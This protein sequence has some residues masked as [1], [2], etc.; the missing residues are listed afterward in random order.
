M[1]DNLVALTILLVVD[2]ESGCGASLL[3]NGQWEGG[4]ES[5]V[6]VVDC[7]PEGDVPQAELLSESVGAGCS[8][9][10]TDTKQVEP[11]DGAEVMCG[12]LFGHV[13]V[14]RGAQEVD[15][16][17]RKSYLPFR[18]R[19][20]SLILFNL[21]REEEGPLAFFCNHRVQFSIQYVG[22]GDGS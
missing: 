6:S 17:V 11:G 7:F 12:L 1:V 5:D 20:I 8:C 16:L 21:A 4:V 22:L 18:G 3:E 13:V 9:V 10:F 15:G 2:A 14:A 19:I